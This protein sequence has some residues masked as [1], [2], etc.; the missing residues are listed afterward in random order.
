MQITVP[1]HVKILNPKIMRFN[2]IYYPKVHYEN[3]ILS[4]DILVIRRICL[5]TELFIIQHELYWFLMINVELRQ[6]SYTQKESIITENVQVVHSFT[7]S[8]YQA[9]SCLALPT[10]TRRLWVT[11]QQSLSTRMSTLHRFHG[12]H[13]LTLS[14]I[15]H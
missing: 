12:C 6:Y 13:M 2:N 8:V 10:R 14:T 11:R 9:S 3:M 5:Y 15:C 7:F 4:I 1:R